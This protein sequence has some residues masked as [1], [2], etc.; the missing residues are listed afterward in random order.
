[1][2]STEWRRCIGCLN[3][4]VSF[5]TRATNYRVLLRKIVLKIRNCMGLR[6]PVLTYSNTKLVCNLLT[7]LRVE[8]M[9]SI[10]VFTE[11][12]DSVM[13]WLRSVGSIKS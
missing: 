7:H 11:H 2:H 8:Q 9:D 4:Q 1:M 10:K 5:G 12:I 6:H 13:G 3:L